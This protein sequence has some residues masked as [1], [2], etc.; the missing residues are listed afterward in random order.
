LD[1]PTNH[2]DISSKNILKEA[3]KNFTG[4]ALI[5]SHDRDFLDG[6]ADKVYEFSNQNL[7]EYIGGIGE[8]LKEKNFNSLSD[9]ELRQKEPKDVDKQ[10]VSENR[11]NYEEQKEQAKKIR[12]QEKLIKASENEIT[13]LESKISELEN[14]FIQGNSDT[15]K[16][17]KY[18]RIKHLLE[19]KLYEWEILC[20]GL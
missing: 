15:E 5:V 2:L 18:Q 16:L 6:L 1:E 20:E 8:Y 9:A 14:D 19:Q 10:A 17:D 4:T 13:K 12:R 11:I 3:V 7:R